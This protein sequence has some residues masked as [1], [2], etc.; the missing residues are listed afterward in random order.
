[1][2]LE[3]IAG[4]LH[5]DGQPITGELPTP[6][7]MQLEDQLRAAQKLLDSCSDMDRLDY[8]K[9]WECV[10][11][12][13]GQIWP[14]PPARLTGKRNGRRFSAPAAMDLPD[15]WHEIDVVN[16]NSDTW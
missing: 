5:F 7:C 10:L 13:E 2:D 4:R 8:A 1:M 14:R 15:G 11:D 6:L 16:K 3:I 12:P 9:T